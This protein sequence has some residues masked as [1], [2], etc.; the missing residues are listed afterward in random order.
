MVDNHDEDED[1]DEEDDVDT[2]NDDTDTGEDDVDEDK[3]SDKDPDA[4]KDDDIAKDT[5]VKSLQA[6]LKK[7]HDARVRERTARRQLTAR[8]KKAEGT[9]KKN[10][11]SPNTTKNNPGRKNGNDPI[12]KRISNIETIEAKRQ[13]GYENSLSPE[14]TDLAF[15]FANGKPSK[16]TLIDPFF[17][18]GLD[19]IRAAKKT[20]ANIPG[21]S[22]RSPSYNAK[23][24]SELTKEDRKKQFED[25][26]KGARA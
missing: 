11:D 21:S 17:K 1:I 8:A 22:R 19:G 16:K 3:D 24:F 18:A 2:N 15:K 20:A 5:D 7:Q 26:I 12:E 25:R 6:K 9:S 13:F 23:P 10:S 14:E 4:L